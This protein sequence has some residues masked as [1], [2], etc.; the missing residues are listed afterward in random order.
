MPRRVLQPL[1]LLAFLAIGGALAGI[2]IQILWPSEVGSFL[3]MFLTRVSLWLVAAS[4]VLAAVTWAGWRIL[5][6]SLTALTTLV[7]LLAAGGLP[8][9]FREPPP[10]LSPRARSILRIIGSGGLALLVTDAAEEPQRRPR[11]R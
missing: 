2:V 4:L 8:L 1:L 7:Q 6:L 10:R 9:I 11:K 3:G 5:R